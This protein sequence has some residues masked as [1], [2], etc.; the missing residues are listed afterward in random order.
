MLSLVQIESSASSST[1]RSTGAS[2]QNNA[3]SSKME[4]PARPARAISRTYPAVPLA[5]T[6]ESTLY[7]RRASTKGFDASDLEMSRPV[8]PV[9]DI[10][11]DNDNNKKK[12]NSDDDNNNRHSTHSTNSRQSGD[13]GSA[14]NSDNDGDGVEVEVLQSMFLPRKNAFRMATV[15]LNTLNDGLND[16]AA[17][18]LLPYIERH[19]N[20][21]YGIVSL[22]FVACAIGSIMA[23]TVVDPMKRRLGRARTL[24]AAQLIMALGYVPV[25]TTLAPFPA[26]VVGFFCVG[27]GEAIN[28]AMGN[29]FC[30]GLQQG[31]LSL[32]IMHGS[33]GI[34]GIS[35][36][37]IATAIAVST[38]AAEHP[39]DKSAVVFGRYYLLPFSVCILTAV[40]SAWSFTG[41]EKDWGEVR[42]VP[43]TPSSTSTDLSER[44]RRWRIG[45]QRQAELDEQQ[46]Q[47][48]TQEQAYYTK[49]AAPAAGIQLADFASSPTTLQRPRPV[50]QPSTAP[51]SR[52]G[53]RATSP[54]PSPTREMMHSARPVLSMIQSHPQ[55]TQTPSE[56]ASAQPTPMH[57]FASS[58]APLFA[59]ADRPAVVTMA[60]PPRGRRGN[61]REDTR[62]QAQRAKNK[63]K[64]MFTAPSSRVILLGA[65]FLFMYQGAEVSI[66]GWVT[67]FLIADRGGQEPAVGY[68][69]AGF[70]AG[71][72]LGR[73]F[74]AWPAQR[75]GARIFVYGLIAGS[76]IFELLVW[77]V[78]NVI[79]DAVAVSIVGL[80][81]GPVY[82]C[83]AGMLMR[84]MSRRE[85]VSG[86]SAMA[87]F[88]SAGGAAAPFIT[89]VLAQAVGTFVLHPIVIALFTAMAVFWY[90]VPDER[91]RQE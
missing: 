40:L 58:T 72:T 77:F 35:G 81:L 64:D 12:N 56:F 62:N 3:S 25:I 60:A 70:W 19:Y 63:L 82:P 21:G 57:S 75:I 83:A 73:F 36:P 91:K 27:L 23:A 89:G 86:M 20:I 44:R 1:A 16:S 38:G 87:A 30:V 45:R 41:Y 32:G 50:S 9:E 68:I 90:F 46:A 48:Q 79:G 49:T 43:G 51:S 11:N 85:R 34:G 28:V 7:E 33:Y 31:T 80:L 10:F 15:A 69:T 67:S 88:G 29:T 47:V 4:A 8:T 74:L 78:P 55:Q 59:P 52:V 18:A 37:L 22:I 61:R 65:V 13:L 66:A 84:L 14:D 17:G 5:E 6:D 24:C 2:H 71:I 76:A 42:E 39:D 26:V 54:A 53:S